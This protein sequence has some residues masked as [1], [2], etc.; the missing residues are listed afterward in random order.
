MSKYLSYIHIL[1]TTQKKDYYIIHQLLTYISLVNK[2]FITVL[3]LLLLLLLL[4][5]LSL[6]V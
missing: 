5:K 2:A 4:L 1:L 3:L 6:S